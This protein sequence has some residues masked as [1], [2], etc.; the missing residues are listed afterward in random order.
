[1]SH[2]RDE[3]ELYEYYYTSASP[4]GVS[5]RGEHGTVV[6]QAKGMIVGTDRSSL[7]EGCTSVV[8]NLSLRINLGYQNIA[9]VSILNSHLPVNFILF[10]LVKQVSQ[11]H[12][13]PH[14]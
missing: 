13:Q 14:P 8:G 10:L 12:A 7:K 4:V 6:S 2:S 1:M 5:R 11:N 3:D 9:I